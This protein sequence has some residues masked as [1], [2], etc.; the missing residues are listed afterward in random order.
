ML[1]EFR[2]NNF[3]SLVNVEFAPTGVNLLLG[4]NNAGKTNLCSALRFV[5]LSS[6]NSVDAAARQALGETWNITNV[7]VNDPGIQFEVGATLEESGQPL[8]FRYSLRL[9]SDRL[10]AAASGRAYS[11]G[12]RV[13]EESLILTGGGFNSTVLL[14]N[15]DGQAR[16]LHEKRFL[17]QAAGDHYVET[18]SPGDAT[19]LSRLYDLETNQRANLFKEYLQN[20]YYFNLSPHALRSADVV[21]D[22]PIIR[23]DGANLSKVLFTLH[24]E[25]PRI[26]RRVIEA[27]RQIEPKLDLFTFNAP[28]PESIFLFLEDE[29]GNRFST[30]S[31]SDGTLRYLAI[32]YLVYAAP[33][34]RHGFRPLILIEEPENGLYVGH[35]KSLL[36]AIDPSGAEGQFVFT[37]QSPYFIDLFE[38]NLE[39]VHLLQPG[40]PSS[41]LIKPDPE[42]LRPLLEEMPLGELH[43]REMLA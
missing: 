3:R 8:S 29:Q 10:R 21:F 33:S 20:W 19:M 31:M 2:V 17:S 37:S 6:F 35:L 39:G 14:E 26:E 7:Y 38:N 41:V 13:A 32:A 40:R 23:C 30:Q 22:E 16:L 27:V 42:R 15:R 43:F 12:L 28:D 5:G 36:A 34:N 1:K 18:L 4:P 25:Q 9:T 11:Q 24:N